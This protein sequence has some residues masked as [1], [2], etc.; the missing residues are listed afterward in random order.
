M[1]KFHGK[2]GY[3]VPTN[4][5]NGIWEDEIVERTY[6]GDVD[7]I[8]RRYD[9]PDA[10]AN[11]DL[12][13]TNTIRVVSDRYAIEHFHNIKYVEWEGVRWTANTVEVK[14]PRL[15]IWLGRVYNGPTPEV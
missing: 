9:N 6:F 4:K 10:K 13:V 14:H 5:G 12:T 15:V 11:P 2:I 7:S 8:F 3:G 1:A